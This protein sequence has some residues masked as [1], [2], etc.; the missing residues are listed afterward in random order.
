MTPEPEKDLPPLPSL[1]VLQEAMQK[2][3]AAARIDPVLDSADPS[4]VIRQVPGKRVILRGLLGIRPAYFRITLDDSKACEREWTELK[5][6]WGYMNT[7]SALVCEP[8]ACVPEH[9]VMAVSEVQGTPLYKYLYQLAP[10]ERVSWLRPC[11]DW[12]RVYTGPT[13]T[14]G[15]CNPKRWIARAERGANNQAFKDLKSLEQEILIELKRLVVKISNT[16][17]RNAICHGD[18]H[19]NNLIVNDQILTGVDCGGSKPMP[20]YKDIARFL[21]HLGRRGMIPSGDR[22]L[23]VDAR[24]FEIFADTFE[25][26]APERKLILPFFLGVEALIRTETR[27]L[28]A[29]RIRRAKEMS[30]S[31]LSDLKT[32][33]A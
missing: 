2:L 4:E 17:G 23:G 16:T 5:R 30:K 22:Y 21:M 11:A 26:T 27:D 9:G 29:S 18:F 3:A 7:G 19:A 24:G 6:V 15:P 32:I 20:I 14:L 10:K 1:E 28:S 12:L 31:L 13:Q 33:A 25:M 8:F